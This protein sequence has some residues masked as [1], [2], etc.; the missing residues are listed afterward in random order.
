M[1]WDSRMKER[2]MQEKEEEEDDTHEHKTICTLIHLAMYT[3]EEN[4]N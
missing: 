1:K 3:H 2:E 4:I